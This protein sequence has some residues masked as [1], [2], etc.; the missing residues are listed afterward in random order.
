MFSPKSVIGSIRSS[1]AGTYRYA[2]RGRS[3]FLRRNWLKLLQVVKLVIE[4]IKDT[5]SLL[6]CSESW[7]PFESRFEIQYP[8]SHTPPAKPEA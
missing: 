7:T 4:I 2:C 1:L 5:R 3:W 8:C 6:F